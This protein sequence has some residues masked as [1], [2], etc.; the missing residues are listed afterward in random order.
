M[1]QLPVEISTAGVA[2]GSDGERVRLSHGDA[3]S[4]SAD[5]KPVSS[6]A[7]RKRDKIDHLM[8]TYDKDGNG[9]FSRD[10]VRNIVSDVVQL[11]QSN[12][13]LKKFAT[14][15]FFLAIAAFMSIF[16]VAL[17]AN[18]VSKEN[19]VTDGGELTALTGET[20][21]VDG[22]ASF[23]TLFD[24]PFLAPRLLSSIKELSCY[25]D[26]TAVVGVGAW[27]QASFRVASSFQPVDVDDLILVTTPEGYRLSINGTAQAGTASMP[28]FSGEPLVIAAAPPA[29]SLY[30][31]GLS[32]GS[33]TMT[34]PPLKD[35]EAADAS[36][37]YS[38]LE[39]AEKELLDD[40]EHPGELEDDGSPGGARRQLR[41]S[42]RS[43]R[44]TS[45]TTYGVSRSSTTH[46]STTSVFIST[47]SRYDDDDDDDFRRPRRRHHG[48]S[49][50]G[51]STGIIVAVIIILVI[52]G[53]VTYLYFNRPNC[54]FE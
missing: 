48:S 18:E 49:N 35:S 46:V 16:I 30:R 10:E 51:S 38:R 53:V 54:C 13:M 47:R 4:S 19:H 45:R 44:S 11:Q 34:A 6:T 41:G 43:R 8:D 25:V 7:V 17:A 15:L 33:T 3:V 28:S 2:L 23:S 32:A 26:M 36:R 40:C 9:T 42:S 5:G 1:S 31:R 22:V 21:Q 24:T 29:E 39:W 14:A 27:V 12:T 52:I 37:L 20:V 50:G